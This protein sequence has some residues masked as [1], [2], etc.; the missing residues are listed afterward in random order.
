MHTVLLH[1]ALFTFRPGCNNCQAF[2]TTHGKMA[3]K[4]GVSR[5]LQNQEELQQL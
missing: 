1:V 5:L 4:Q 3:V 2:V